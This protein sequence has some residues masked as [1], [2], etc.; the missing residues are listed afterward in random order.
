MTIVISDADARR[1]IAEDLDDTLVVCT[2]EF[3]RTP[4]LNSAGGRDHWTHCWSGLIAGGGIEG[5][6]V[7]GATDSRGRSIVDR[8]VSLGELVAT[9]YHSLRIDPRAPVTLGERAERLLD[10]DPVTSLWA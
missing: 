7:I 5:G 1:A 6:Q 3:G 9:A 2:G 4:H 10:A 8:P